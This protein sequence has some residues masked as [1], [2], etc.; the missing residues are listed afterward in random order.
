MPSQFFYATVNDP[1]YDLLYIDSITGHVRNLEYANTND[2][3]GINPDVLAF[4]PNIGPVSIV[5]TTVHDPIAGI[6]RFTYALSALSPNLLSGTF[7]ART[8]FTMTPDHGDLFFHD[9]FTSPFGDLLAVTSRGTAGEQQSLLWVNA[10]GHET[11]EL[12]SLPDT[13]MVQATQSEIT[14]YDGFSY[15]GQTYIIGQYFHV[16]GDALGG[17]FR[18]HPTGE[19]TLVDN[20]SVTDPI[21]YVVSDGITLYAS[22]IAP[23]DFFGEANVIYQIGGVPLDQLSPI[24]NLSGIEPFVGGFNILSELTPADVAIPFPTGPSESFSAYGYLASYSDLFAAFGFAAALAATHYLLVGRGEGRA[25]TFDGL[26]Y[27]ASYGDLIAAIGPDADAGAYHYLA[28]GRA[29]GRSVTFDP[30]AYTAS[31]DDLIEAFGNNSDQASAHFIASGFS[32]GR[33]VSFDG[34][35]YIAG[36]GD[37]IRAFGANKEAGATHFLESGFAEGRGRD[38]FDAEQYLANYA[39][40]RAAFGS[41]YN[42]VTLH[43]ITHGFGEGRSD[44]P[45][46]ATDFIL[47]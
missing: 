9:L 16:I 29:E 47:G 24:I 44:S 11:V 22:G 19:M 3:P 8:I 4:A 38:Q 20:V 45:L 10:Q 37:L 46:P 39:D 34:L 31:Y 35:Q 7:T 36:Y 30:L 6:D 2:E 41:D 26:A 21:R 14:W 40:L 1:F 18:V 25:V 17:V 43:Y 23:G 42:A 27:V 28:V 13:V 15:G 33:S 5:P 12:I 32:E